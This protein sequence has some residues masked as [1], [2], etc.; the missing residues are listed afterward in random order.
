MHESYKY[1]SGLPTVILGYAN[2]SATTASRRT[3]ERVCGVFCVLALEIV[4]VPPRLNSNITILNKGLETSRE[5]L[6]LFPKLF[7][8]AIITSALW[9]KSLST[10]SHP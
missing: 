9:K 5:H 4:T 6:E 2:A 8:C 3:Q 1:Q 7:W 10:S